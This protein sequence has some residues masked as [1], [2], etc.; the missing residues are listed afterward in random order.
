[1]SKSFFGK[2]KTLFGSKKEETEYEPKDAEKVHG[3]AE[4]E[5]ETQTLTEIPRQEEVVTLYEAA[6][7]ETDTL[8]E[9]RESEEKEASHCIKEDTLYTIAKSPDEELQEEPESILH[10][11]EE[12][13]PV[14]ETPTNW[15]E[16]DVIAELYKIKGSAAGGQGVVYFVDHLNWRIP[17]AVKTPLPHLMADETIMKRFIREAE[18]WVDLGMHP[19]IATCFYVRQ[20]GGLPR[21]FIEYVDGGSLKDWIRDGKVKDWKDILDFAIQFCRGM[22]YAHTKGVIHRDIKPAN[23]LMT[24]DGTLKITDFGLVKSLGVEEI[25]GPEGEVSLSSGVVG[26]TLTVT[27]GGMGTP[28]Y[29]APEQFESAK[30]VGMEADIYSFG[31]MLFEM[32]TGERPFVVSD[33]MH[34]A[35]R[36]HV[37]QQA[38][39]SE[40]P[41]EPVSL[42]ENCP[43]PL[44]DLILECL[45]KDP[46]KRKQNYPT[47]EPV[48]SELEAL[49]QE[50]VGEPYPRKKVEELSL[51]ATSLNNKGVSLYDLGQKDDALYAFSEAIKIDPSHPEAAYNQMILLWEKNE[52]TDREV[53]PRMKVV[54]N[55]LPDDWMPHYLLGLVH[56]RRKDA[57]GAESA[58]NKAIKIAPEELEPKIAL[59]QVLAEKDNWPRCLRTLKGHK[60]NEVVKMHFFDIQTIRLHTAISSDGRFVLSWKDFA[61][62]VLHLWDFKKGKHL[63]KLEGH[64]NG[65][66]SIAISPDGKFAL[67]GSF[68]ENLA[69]ERDKPL[70]LWDL[71]KGKCL[72]ALEGLTSNVDTVRFSPDGRSAISGS[73]DGTLCLWDIETGECLRTFE[74]HKYSV[75]SVAFHPDGG[76]ALSGSLD[77]NLR[78]WDLETGECLRTREGNI[79]E[80]DSFAVSTDGRFALL[81]CHTNNTLRLWDIKTGECLRTLKGHT[82]LVTSA[83]FTSNERF[84][85]SGSGDGTLCL[86]D[87]ETGECLR[88]I[89]NHTEPCASV[90]FSPNGRFAGR[91]ALS[92]SGDETLYLWDMGKIDSSKPVLVLGRIRALEEVVTL[93]AEYATLKE[94]A[95][96]CIRE[97]KWLKAIASL[98]KAKALPGYER[99]PEVLELLARVGQKGIKRSLNAAWSLRTLKGHTESVRSVAFSQDGRFALS[100]Y[101]KFASLHSE[102]I[103]LRFWD[104]ETGE[105]LRTLEGHKKDNLTFSPEFSPNGRFALALDHSKTLW[106][107]DLKKGKLLRSLEEYYGS[108]RSVV[109][110]PDGIFALSG[111]REKKTPLVGDKILHLWDLKT[112]E[113]LHTLKGH[114]GPVWSFNTSPDGRFALS[115]SYDKLLCLWDLK[116]GKCLRTLKGHKDGVTSV[117]F[118][119][120]GRFALSSGM[121]DKTLRLWDLETGKILRTLKGKE[122]VYTLTFSQDGRF[123]LSRDIDKNLTIWDLKKGKRLHTLKGRENVTASF[124]IS[125]DGIFA[126]SLGMEDKT[127]RI[128]DFKK[129]KYLHTLKGHTDVVTSFTVSSDGRFVLSNSLDRT[130]RLWDLK[131]GECLH[132]LE[133]HMGPVTAAA[134]SQD[135]RFALSGSGDGTLRLWEFDWDYKFPEDKDW[136]EGAIPYLETFLTLHT[137]YTKDSIIHEGTP[138]WTEED[139]QNLLIELALRGYGWL[140]EEGVRNKLLEMSREK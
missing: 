21:I 26:G 128:W 69:G 59:E 56:I 79:S 92:E 105:C 45:E 3:L 87:I 43:K 63:R 76:L 41:P 102:D 44:N 19:N 71:K 107:W 25:E 29:M 30:E 50:M 77:G 52:I 133:G 113:C 2:I 60:G 7:K 74:G 110:A 73:E 67:S 15:N 121:R 33:E 42:H 57:E 82:G 127:L 35:A 5:E 24:E 34:P 46:D 16:G 103:T 122:S 114:T 14:K 84:A 17:L 97:K 126:L 136:D 8:L 62:G 51:L 81:G 58:I 70:L 115:G 132:T 109:F 40:M 64:K 112:G 1:M 95:E 4:R 31:V 104:L 131:T 6:S 139:F 39:Q 99:H 65:V 66:L 54:C 134:F 100:S 22:G 90:A 108:V 116:T 23:C 32:V 9:A 11:P 75:Y 120:D 94:E 119:P 80:Y 88:T 78:L 47:F 93:Q 111:V 36:G 138:D 89:E 61:D 85:L 140:K 55:N 12:E 117:A 18:V 68:Y 91:F 135:G 118:S 98:Q 125:P 28:E 13:G 130:L 49:Y 101:R 137:P 124:V 123:A 53:I 20:I 86:W 27:G 38:H 37:Y 83:A 72:R 48:L 106:L 129:G 10:E 96:K